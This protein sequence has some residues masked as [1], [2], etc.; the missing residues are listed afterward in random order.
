MSEAKPIKRSLDA[1]QAPSLSVMSMTTSQI[2]KFDHHHQHQHLHDDYDPSFSFVN[3]SFLHA[4]SPAHGDKR[5][6]RGR[7]AVLLS[8][9]H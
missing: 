4:K 3:V 6:S 1:A 9:I 2:E 7:P 5:G 8:P